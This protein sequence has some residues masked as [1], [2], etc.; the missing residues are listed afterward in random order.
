MKMEQRVW[1]SSA[2]RWAAPSSG[3]V[4]TI[5]GSRFNVLHDFWIGRP[6]FAGG[7][8]SELESALIGGGR[9]GIAGG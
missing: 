5:L 7:Q 2:S 8:R 9:D 6:R 1:P 3:V 4:R